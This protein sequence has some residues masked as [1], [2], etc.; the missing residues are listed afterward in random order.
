MVGDNET[1]EYDTPSLDQIYLEWDYQNDRW[2]LEKS[3][4]YADEPTRLARYGEQPF[5]CYRAILGILPAEGPSQNQ[6]DARKIE[7]TETALSPCKTWLRECSESHTL[8]NQRQETFVPTRL[9]SF[10]GDYISLCLTSELATAPRYASLSHCWGKHQII[11]LLKDNLEEFR[12]CIPPEQLSKTF[13]EA[14]ETTQYLGL[15]YI[16]IDSLCII[17]DDAGDWAKEAAMMSGVYGGSSVNIAASGA[18]D[19]TVGCFFD[20]LGSP[21]FNFS[22]GESE[23]EVISFFSS[24][25]LTF[26]KQFTEAPLSTRG[27]CFQESFL[28]RRTLH[29]THR[30]VFWECDERLASESFPST[31]PSW[32]ANRM[33]LKKQPLTLDTWAKVVDEYSTRQLTFSKDKLVAVSGLAK[34]FELEMKDDYVFGLWK[35]DI[36]EQ[37]CWNAKFPAQQFSPPTAPSWSWASLDGTINSRN[38]PELNDFY[39]LA[40]VQNIIINDDIKSKSKSNSNPNFHPHSRVIETGRI[41]VHAKYIV[42]AI[43]QHN[44][45]D[46]SRYDR[47]LIGKGKVDAWTNWDTNYMAGKAKRALMSVVLMPIKCV[48]GG[49]PTNFLL[50]T[51]ILDKTAATEEEGRGVYKR[52][53]YLQ[54]RASEGRAEL[55]YELHLG[56]LGNVGSHV[57][58]GECVEI[59]GI[60]GGEREF[61]VDFI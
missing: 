57:E 21:R 24:F 25:P 2:V 30:E 61:V 55:D 5:H 46:R 40:R 20:R 1:Y 12:T 34:I 53:G 39:T 32:A 47:L 48:T 54:W 37:L 11:V 51:L 23:E 18:M 42:H 58:A 49:S 14:I 43:F 22:G 7:S 9:V 3:F 6:R 28:P 10:D 38:D 16:W 15:Q 56:Y 36:E 41:R 27:C 19:G 26:E 8:C 52:I 45:S 60:E 13:R 44:G 4:P 17:Q 31:I 59:R 35:R 50:K 29:F 33:Q